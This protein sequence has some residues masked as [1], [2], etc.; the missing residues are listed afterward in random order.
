[1]P[2]GLRPPHHG[3]PWS[4][5]TSLLRIVAEPIAA[6]T[7][8]HLLFSIA[9]LFSGSLAAQYP[10]VPEVGSPR[11]T[12][13]RPVTHSTGTHVRDRSRGDAPVNDNCA[14]AILITVHPYGSCPG[15]SLAGDNTD[16]TQDPSDVLCDLAESQIQDVWYTFTTGAEYNVI[17]T[18][19]P[20]NG[21]SDWA[22][23]IYD[24]CGGTSGYC[25]AQPIAALVYPLQPSTTY[26]LSV[27]SNNDYGTAGEFEL[28][29]EAAPAPPV[30]DVCSNV[31]PEPMG[32]GAT[33]AFTGDATGAANTENV[34][35]ASVWHAVTLTEPADLTIDFCGSDAFDLWGEFYRTIYLTCPPN[36][37]DRVW[38]GSYDVT[39]CTDDRLTLCYAKL[40]A[41]TY[42][43]PVAAPIEAG[44]GYTMNV[45]TD[46]YGSHV[47]PN[48]ECAG[49]IPLT[50]NATCDPANYLPEC[51]SQSLPAVDCGV[52]N[53]A[54]N[55]DVWYFFTAP[56]DVVTL[57]V[58]AHSNT[59]SPTIDVY[60]GNCG[61]LVPYECADAGGLD[62]TA[63]LILTGLT[64]DGTYFFRIYNGYGTTPLDDASYDLCAV[65]GDDLGIGVEENMNGTAPALFPNP[66]DGDFTMHVDVRIAAVDLHI[67]DMT[68]R[69]V[70]SERI[71]T[72]HGKILVHA[73]ST[74][75]SGLYTARTN[76]GER[77]HQA[78]LVIR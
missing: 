53:A 18:L 50:V 52:P 17:I 58:F 15:M 46:A 65:E 78:Q 23:G 3:V 12:L 2:I 36:Y 19:N 75:P 37:V 59:Y 8:K 69:A 21:M 1:M 72:R 66:S 64:P 33:L 68:G 45:R 39:T 60:S 49:A 20:G 31:I 57:A 54:A 30:N 35:Y 25:I 32:V 16:A 14:N 27:W 41:G 73:A 77:I 48:D 76:D 9:A 55:D 5:R 38:A 62:N 28:C 10:A 67:F 11:S 42:Y 13:Q 24:G 70:F 29:I 43:L 47:P 56:S 44:D 61:S 34:A 26:W 4:F 6:I 40:D 71:P 7:M 74:L 51:P 63:Q 22:M